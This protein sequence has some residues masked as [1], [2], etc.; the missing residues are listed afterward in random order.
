MRREEE[1]LIVHERD[2]KEEEEVEFKVHGVNHI[3]LKTPE[4]YKYQVDWGEAYSED[5]NRRTMER[6]KNLTGSLRKVTEY[7]DGIKKG[8]KQWTK[9]RPR[10]KEQQQ[11][12]QSLHK[13]AFMLRE[14]KWQQ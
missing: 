13:S 1:R 8:A 5:N 10:S 11:W 12:R 4:L 3:S 9:L 7:W 6:I 14:Y 2:D